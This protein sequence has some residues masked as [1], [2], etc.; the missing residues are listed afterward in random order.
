M[1]KPNFFASQIL[2]EINFGRTYF[3][4][5]LVKRDHE[6]WIHIVEIFEIYSY[7]PKNISSNQLFNNLFSKTVIFTKFFSKNSWERIPPV[8]HR[9]AVWNFTKKSTFLRQINGS[10]KYLISRKFERDRIF[11]DFSSMH[12]TKRIAI[13]IPSE[14]WSLKNIDIPHCEVIRSSLL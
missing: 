12:F 9:A 2:R 14:N 1:E 11:Y 4:N 5:Y 13:L 3:G 8:I 6:W 10:S 7:L